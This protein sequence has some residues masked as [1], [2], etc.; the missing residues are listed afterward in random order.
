MTNALKKIQKS[1]LK[2]S[3]TM[4]IPVFLMTAK[5]ALSPEIT[6]G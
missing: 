1:K 4:S 2:V 3:H 5:I 6:L